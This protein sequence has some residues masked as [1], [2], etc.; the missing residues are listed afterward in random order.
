VGGGG[1]AFP[2]SMHNCGRHRLKP[3]QYRSY[4]AEQFVAYVI[5]RLEFFAELCCLQ[6]CVVCNPRLFAG[7]VVAGL[8]C[9]Q[10]CVVFRTALFVAGLYCMRP[11]LYAACVVYGLCCSQPVLFTSLYC[12]QPYVVCGL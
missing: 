11:V 10:D 3:G 8:C 12:L 2:A 9:S 5:C 6:P 1:D 4:E 7:C